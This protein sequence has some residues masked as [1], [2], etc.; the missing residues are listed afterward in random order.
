MKN[1]I[2][3]EKWHHEFEPIDKWTKEL[4]ILNTDKILYVKEIEVQNEKACK[5]ICSPKE[6]ELIVDATLEHMGFL[7]HN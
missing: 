4:I 3:V 7:L 5:I 1:M 6:D 2:K